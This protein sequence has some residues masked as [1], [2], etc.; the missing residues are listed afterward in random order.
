[1]FIK[2][3]RALS[4]HDT[5]GYYIANDSGNPTAHRLVFQ[6]YANENLGSPDCE[7]DG[8]ISTTQGKGKAMF[9]L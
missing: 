3:K 8:T 5:A 1:M 9:L 6:V 4:H 2:I 7:F